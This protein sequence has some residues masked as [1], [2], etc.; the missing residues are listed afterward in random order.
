MHDEESSQPVEKK[1]TTLPP[2]GEARAP[3][4]T[5]QRYA[6][7][8]K[9]KA[10]RLHLEEGFSRTAITEELGLGVHTLTH[11]LDRYHAYGEEGLRSRQAGPHPGE[12]KLPPAVT[13]KIIELKKENPSF[14][15]KRIAQW[16]RRVFF[17]QASAETVRAKLHEAGL[18]SRKPAPKKRNFTRPRFFERAT[19]DVD[20][21]AMVD[22]LQMEPLFV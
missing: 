5:S 22:R 1:R 19:P 18:M 3:G 14:G 16:L 15:V 7:E 2:R 4:K 6:F 9:L 8:T 21:Q 11:W 12:P 10:V 17:L 20:M 13:G